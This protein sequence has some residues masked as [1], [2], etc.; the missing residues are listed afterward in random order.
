[1]VMKVF[2]ED[3]KGYVG[4]FNNIWK[5]SIKK[6]NGKNTLILRGNPARD[7]INIPLS[8]IRLAYALDNV[9]LE[10]YFRYEK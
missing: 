5:I 1:M 7:E 9:N 8:K 10:E 2:I 6:I 4:V 3:N